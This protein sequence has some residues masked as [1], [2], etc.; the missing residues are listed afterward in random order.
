MNNPCI[1]CVAITGSLPT[2]DNNPAVPITIAEQIDRGVRDLFDEGERTR[3]RDLTIG[4]AR[5]MAR[6]ATRG[7][8]RLAHRVEAV[9]RRPVV[10]AT[11]DEQASADRLR[12]RRAASLQ[13]GRLIPALHRILS[14]RFRLIL[15]A[16]RE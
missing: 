2:K 8:D 14:V 9:L 16:G 5:Q 1:I 6:P 3:A 10:V 13:R 12:R 4:R 7:V 11:G 15:T